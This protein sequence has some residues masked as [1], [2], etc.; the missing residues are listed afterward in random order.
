VLDPVRL[1][2][3]TALGRLVRWPLRLVPRGAVLHVRSGPLQGARWVAGSSVHGCWLGTYERDKALAVMGAIRPGGVAYD[4]GANAGYYTLL[5]SRRVGPEGRVVA[6]EPLPG[7]LASLLRNIELNEVTNTTVFASAVSAADGWVGFQPGANNAVGHLGSGA[8]QLRVATVSLDAAISRGLPP[9]DLVKMDVEGA[10]ADV[11]AGASV[12][13]A[14]RRT[15]WFVSLHGAGPREACVGLL[16]SSGY[17]LTDVAGQQ[18][19]DAQGWQGDELVARPPP[20]G[21]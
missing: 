3:S 12:L 17:E 9:P 4:V 19:G 18:L 6:F 10:E 15:T 13:L 11:L 16:R 1:P 2:S 8:D 14:M 5:L 21:R 7:N 20:T